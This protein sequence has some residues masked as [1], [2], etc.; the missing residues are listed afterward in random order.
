MPPYDRLPQLSARWARM[1]DRGLDYAVDADFARFRAD[2]FWTGSPTPIAASCR[3]SWR[4]LCCG[5]GASSRPGCSCTPATTGST[6][7]RRRHRLPPRACPPSAWTAA[8]CSSARPA[9]SARLHAD[10]GAA[11]EVRLRPIP[12]PEWLPL[13]YDTGPTTS[14]SPP[15]GPKRLFAGNDRIVDNNLVTGG[16]T[17][18]PLDPR[19]APRRCACR[20]RNATAS[21]QQVTP[22][23][24][25]PTGA[26]CPT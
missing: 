26:D 18:R 22:A 24:R 23:R 7:I 16:L 25:L 1:N 19:L 10:A 13:A 15:S 14:T 6:P 2:P 3:R 8:R 21:P 12:R 4:R 9:F 11:P 17:T 5:P 20:W